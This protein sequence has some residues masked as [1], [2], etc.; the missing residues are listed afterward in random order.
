MSLA[1]IG[2]MTLLGLLVLVVTGVLPA[3]AK[4]PQGSIVFTSDRGGQSDLWTMRP[5]G[6]NQVKTDQRQDRGRVSHVA[7][8]GRKIAWTR[9]GAF[10]PQA[11]LPGS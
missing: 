6:S 2:A 11:G 4:P 5:D 7:P 8:D 1:P 9:G 10:D 3:G